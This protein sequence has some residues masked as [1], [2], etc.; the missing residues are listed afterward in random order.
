VPVPPPFLTLEDPNAKIK[1]SRDPLGI[2]PVW[3][4][5][6]R[7]FVANLTNT[8]NLVRNFS[9]LL[10]GRYFGKRLLDER[11]ID[12][13]DLLPVF[14]RVEQACAYVRPRFGAEGAA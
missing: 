8:T 11:R 14:L 12:Q 5:F 7:H 4:R 6:A 2:Q 10:L 9:V 1:G 3:E 13:D